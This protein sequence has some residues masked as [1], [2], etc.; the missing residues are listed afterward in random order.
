LEA[1]LVVLPVTDRKW[2]IGTACDHNGLGMTCQPP[3]LAG[4]ALA[5][6]VP[7]RRR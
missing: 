6:N 5:G 4:G 7:L 1:C 3:N 2:Q